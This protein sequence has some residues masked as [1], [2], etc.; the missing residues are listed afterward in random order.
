MKESRNDDYSPEPKVDYNE[1]MIR[2]QYEP[3]TPQEQYK[4]KMEALDDSQERHRLLQL[5]GELSASWEML[6]MCD[7][8]QRPQGSSALLSLGY[9]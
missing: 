6:G 1:K 2:Q 8:S 7:D 4:L 3:M 5:Y 9:G